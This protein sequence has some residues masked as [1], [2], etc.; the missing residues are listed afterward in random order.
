MQSSRNTL[1]VKHLPLPSQG[2]FCSKGNRYETVNYTNLGLITIVATLNEKH[3][4]RSL[5]LSN[6]ESGKAP[7]GGA[8]QS[9][10]YEKTGNN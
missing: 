10:K 7:G 8:I 1:C 6:P 2:L 9:K 4:T 5:D 3:L